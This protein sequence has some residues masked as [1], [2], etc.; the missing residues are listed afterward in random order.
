MSV[1]QLIVM[2]D[3]RQQ[4]LSSAWVIPYSGQSL[5]SYSILLSRHIP[6]QYVVL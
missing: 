1:L 2:P 5:H 6:L 4:Q 3:V